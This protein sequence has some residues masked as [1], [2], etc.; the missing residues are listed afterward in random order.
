MQIT[1]LGQAGLFVETRYGSILCDPWFNPAF[2]ASWVPFPSNE[3]ID[4]EM[5]GHPDYLYVS[6]L[7]HD[8]FDPRFLAERV[9]KEATVLLPDYPL[10]HLEKE[11]RALGFSKFV[12]TKNGELVQVNGLR[13]AILALVAPTDGP[14]GDSALMLDDG[15]TRVFN[16]NDSHP[17][18]LDALQTLG[19]FDAHFLQFSGAIWY[20]MVYDFPRRM[21]E[22][23]GHKKRINQQA[24]AFQY[25]EQIGAAHV[26]PSAGPPCY[27][28]DDLFSLNDLDRDPTNIF[29]DQT[30]FIEYMREHGN[31]KGRLVVPGSVITLQGPK[32]TI[33][34]PMPDHEVQAIFRDK[35][36]YLRAYQDRQ[37]SA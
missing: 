6:H 13:V 5:I 27:L 1:F 2:F 25:A 32:A 20:P 37:R 34:H 9:S 22:A 30:V 3:G 26:F 19:P 24:R 35:E 21:K 4:R 11:L 33:R 36:G 16:Q 23:L 10:D 12:H 8:H 31:D 7:H 18:D 28:D 17:M 29:C 15:E 14:I